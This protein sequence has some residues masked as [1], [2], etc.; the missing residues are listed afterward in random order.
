MSSARSAV[1]A[2]RDPR[3]H[4]APPR[5]ATP[6]LRAASNAPR[7]PA[8]RGRGGR[9]GLS[10]RCAPRGGGGWNP[11]PVGSRG[12]PAGRD[13]AAP[14]HASPPPAHA[15]PRPG[16]GAVRGTNAAR[17]GSGGA[18][19]GLGG[20]FA[21][22]RGPRHADGRS[23]SAR[24]EPARSRRPLGL[25]RARQTPQEGGERP[26]RRGRAFRARRGTAVSVRGPAP[27]RF[28]WR[29]G[30][31]RERSP[32]S[33]GAEGS[34]CR[35]ATRRDATRGP[36]SPPRSPPRPGADRLR[37]P[38]FLQL[39]LR[40]PADSSGDARPR[41]RGRGRAGPKRRAPAD[42]ARPPPR[43]A[44]AAL[45]APAAAARGDTWRLLA[46]CPLPPPTARIA[47]VRTVFSPCHLRP[48]TAPNLAP[49][50]PPLRA[51][52]AALPALA[53][54]GWQCPCCW[55]RWRLQPLWPCCSPRLPWQP[56]WPCCSPWL[57]WLQ[58]L[59][60]PCCSP[61]LP[62]Q[63]PVAPSSPAYQ[64]GD[65]GL[66]AQSGQCE[67]REESS[68]GRDQ[69]PVDVDEELEEIEIVVV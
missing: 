27:G 39:L 35:D 24:G 64:Q 52:W 28:S 65:H 29:R 22:R 6:R 69:G 48:L 41:L 68:P 12:Q 59:L 15:E 26:A 62:S 47:P 37:S 21:L 46:P 8:A 53:T 23:P 49:C 51:P 34:P 20:R 44:A 5:T 55:G 11:E 14:H 4:A 42:A 1:G 40:R 38:R 25:R 13:P 66:A 33:G 7:A 60:W 45:P 63:P 32:G 10:G 3:L 31:S 18:V 17:P 58:P 9:V 19:R 16:E 43:A 30:A 56:L 36:A 2:R 57:P 50:P 54:P 67:G 61:R